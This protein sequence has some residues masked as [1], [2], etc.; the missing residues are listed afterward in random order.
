MRNFIIIFFLFCY[1]LGISQNYYSEN[2]TSVNGLPDN[3]IRAI[4]KDS[5]GYIWIGT[6][7]GISK[8][9]GESFRNYNTLDGLAGNK[10][11]CIEEDDKGNMWFACFGGGLSVFN[12]LEFNSYTE[13]DGLINNAVRQIKYSNQFSCLAIGTGSGFSLYKDSVFH[14][15][16]PKVNIEYDRTII[17]GIL[18]DEEGLIFLDF[19]KTHYKANITD[20]VP[21]IERYHLGKNDYKI[22]SVYTNQAENYFGWGR[23]G[24]IAKN[25]DHITEF[26]SIGQV[27]G[28]SKDDQNQLWIASWNGGN[29]FQSSSGGLFTI[30]KEKAQTLNRAYQINSILGWASF[31]ESIQH[32]ILYG[33]LDKGLY[34]IPPQ[35][36]EYYP[37]EYFG[38]REL[39]IKDIEVDNNNDIWMISDDLLIIKSN[40]TYQKE[41]IELFKEIPLKPQ[42]TKLHPNIV[43]RDKSLRRYFQT[44]EFDHQNN[45]RVSIEVIGLFHID[46]NDIKK[47]SYHIAHLRNQFKYDEYDSLF[48]AHTWYHSLRKYYDINKSYD[49]I[50]YSDS[51]FSILSKKMFSYKNEIWTIGRIQNTYFQRDGIFRNIN[52]ED[53]TINKLVNDVCFD[54]NGYAFLGGSDGRVEILAPI[55]RKKVFE[56]NH[57][58]FGNSVHWLQST[59]NRL[60][61]GYS[62]G[63]RVYKLED[64]Y[65]SNSSFQYYSESEGYKVSKVLNSQTDKNGNICLGTDNGLLKINTD[66]M[67]TDEPHPLKTIIQKVDVFNKPFDWKQIISTDDWTSLP[68]K[69]PRLDSEQNHISIYYHTINYANTDYDEYFYIL[70]GIDEDWSEANDRK[71]VIFPNLSPGK[72]HFLVKSRNR[73]SGLYSETAEFSFIIKRPWYKQIWFYILVI[74]IIIISLLLIYKRRIHIIEKKEKKKREVFQKIS[75]LESKALQ[76][77]M[78]PHFLFNSLNSIQS[79]ILKNDVDEALLYLNSFSR[80]IRMTLDFASKKFIPLSDEIAYLK[81]YTALENM[82]FD[83]L[84]NFEI[85]IHPQI[86][87]DSVM[88]LPMITQIIVE[89]AIKHGIMLLNSPGKILFTVEK[90]NENTYKCIIKDN[91]IGRKSAQE[92]KEKQGYFHESKGLK[93]VS[94]RL[95]SLNSDEKEIYKMKIIDLLDENGLSMGTQVELY[96]PY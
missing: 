7:A 20:S 65:G 80:V 4:Y 86:H 29:Q 92:T 49:S 46:K 5:R 43:K 66:L 40:N 81:H 76:A 67:I 69:T 18:E 16:D 74:L 62:D 53:S 34:K 90:Y 24:I 31:Y 25:Q 14:N 60:F 87:P 19:M 13:K 15:Y 55:S 44:L 6:D 84:F 9:D 35:Y 8:W 26:D 33:T 89:N 51:S 95:K 57:Q 21:Q 94:D 42:P 58:K 73:H 2:I 93:L 68:I 77:Q 64:L 82:R 1:S 83:N 96:L 38:E 17:T 30:E 45:A 54:S 59:K 23:E 39:S 27:F 70:E 52:N 11:W 78:N 72:Y 12:G 28:I 50:E 22:S 63:M 88:I 85:S 32:R 75:E 48:Y 37:P 10:V 41:S 71:Y 61:V 47:N 79:F 36:F 56:I 91:G 3:A